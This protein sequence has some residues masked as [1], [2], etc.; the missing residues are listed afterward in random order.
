MQ[1][2]S[3]SRRPDQQAD[4]QTSPVMQRHLAVTSHE[5]A[6]PKDTYRNTSELHNHQLMWAEILRIS[7]NTIPNF[8]SQGGKA[9]PTN[10]TTAS[11]ELKMAQQ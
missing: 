5:T 4:A 9:T 8:S 7:N 2:T 1:C 11:Y 10:L 6:H 3:Q